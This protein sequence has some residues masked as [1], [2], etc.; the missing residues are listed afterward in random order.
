MLL[1]SISKFRFWRFGSN[2][3]SQIF[4]FLCWLTE[5]KEKNALLE[6]KFQEEEEKRIES[7]RMRKAEKERQDDQMMQMQEKFKQELQQQ[8]EMDRAIES[9]LKEQ[10][11]MIKKGFSEKADLL[12]E[13]ITNLKKEKESSGGFMKE[14]VTPILGVVAEMLPAVLNYK[15]LMKGLKRL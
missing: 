5:E 4:C 11:E 14:Y 10:E 7:E 12:N 6:Q 15:V 8:Q 1:K 3:H 2:I 9:K 13:E